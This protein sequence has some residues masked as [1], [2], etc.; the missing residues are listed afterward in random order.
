MEGFRIS[1]KIVIRGFN[2][3]SI[4][5]II[6]FAAD[7]NFYLRLTVEKVHAFLILNDKYLR[8]HGCSDTNFRATVKCTNP[9]TEIKVKSL[10]YKS[11]EYKST[12]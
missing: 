3:F 8:L 6:I 9:E 7:K 10:K 5:F 2:F 4:N 11:L 1:Y 12:L